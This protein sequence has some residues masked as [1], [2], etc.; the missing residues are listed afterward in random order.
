MKH[1]LPVL[2][3]FIAVQ[4]M[5]QSYPIG[6][7][8]I[9]YVDPSRNNRQIAC[10]VYYPAT[11]AGA[12]QPVANG[13]FPVV[14]F[15]HGFVMGV[16]AYQN[17]WEQVVP[18]GYIM[19]LPTTEG[20]IPPSHD[21]FAQD[22]KFVGNEMV[23][24]GATQG[25][26]WSGKVTDRICIMGHSM[27]GGATVLASA[28]NTA[29]T[30]LVT[31]AAAETT[32]SAQAAAANITVPALM[33]YGT[34]DNV[35]PEADHG[36]PMFNNMASACKNYVRI[37]NGSHCYF[38]NY[39]FNC[40]LGEAI[41]GSL[42]RE[43]QQAKTYALVN[44]WLDYFLKD[45][46]AAWQTL[47]A[48]INGGVTGINVTNLC[49]NPTPV[50]AD[51]TGSLSSTQAPT[52]QWFLDG[53]PISGAN[54]QTYTYTQGGTYYVETITVGNCPLQSNSITISITGLNLP[55][56][57]KFNYFNGEIVVGQT[58]IYDRFV[59]VDALGRTIASGNIQSNRQALSLPLGN[60]VIITLMG[61]N[62][63][64]SILVMPQ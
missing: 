59:V 41:P 27:G 37:A 48:G 12:D 60:P 33:F 5:G 4:A 39:N 1:L 2:C 23:A 8:N 50:I 24:A 36:L 19:I 63:Q 54:Q 55:D 35:T 3:L 15:G 58:G 62:A 13:Q 42:A 56:S 38:A 21:N 10:Q 51:Q 45:N 11:V 14:V 25:G 53:Q 20:G 31:L 29:I 34:S 30:C 44:P 57:P 43:Q 7:R 49:P 9:T 28:N 22:L 6:S 64:R 18:R 46:C 17:W 61:K 52:Y 40:A 47:Q 32:P 16:S 26:F